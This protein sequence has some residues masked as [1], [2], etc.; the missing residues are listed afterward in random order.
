MTAQPVDRAGVR[1]AVVLEP[2]LIAPHGDQY[3]RPVQAFPGDWR[4]APRCGSAGERWVALDLD[5]AEL[6][7]RGPCGRCW[8]GGVDQLAIIDKGAE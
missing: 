2:V 4:L 5:F 3:H 1:L 7:D 6:L 8:N